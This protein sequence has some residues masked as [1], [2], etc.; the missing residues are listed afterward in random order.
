MFYKNQRH[1]QGKMI[2]GNGMVYEGDWFEGK[3]HGHGKLTIR[4]HVCIGIFE[5]NEFVQD[6]TSQFEDMKSGVS[7]LLQADHV[8]S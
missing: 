2:Y 7:G 5:D 8:L 6:L 1:G 3:Q 4:E